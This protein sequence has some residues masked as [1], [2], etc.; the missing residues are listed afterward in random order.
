LCGSGCC[1]GV[2]GIGLSTTPAS[3]AVRPIDL[4]DRDA[5]VM[6]VAGETSAVAA[7]AFDPDELDLAES[8]QPREQLSVARR[9]R[10]EVCN[11]KERS[12]V[13]E[14]SRDVHIEV[15]VDTTGDA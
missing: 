13:V 1:D 7:G 3:L 15:R 4:D 10:R 6:E 5:V 2:F 9:S 11:T 12:P 14:R 8:L